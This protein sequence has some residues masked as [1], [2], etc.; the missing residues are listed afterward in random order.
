MSNP[1]NSVH[2]HRVVR[3]PAERIYRAFLDADALARWL[4]P[5]GFTG[6]VHSMEAEVGSGYRMSFTNFGNGQS[7]F[8]TTR[9]TELKPHSCLRY[10]N[11]FEAPNM[12]GEMAVTVNLRGV[13]C[14]TEVKIVQENIPAQIPAEFCYLGWQESLQQLIRL[15]EPEIPSE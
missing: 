1:E 13:L 3:A 9:Y 6:K 15:V 7:H 11:Q 8:F 2:L 12:P 4:P 10:V 5:Y 14:G